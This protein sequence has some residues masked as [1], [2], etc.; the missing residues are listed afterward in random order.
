MG[1]VAAGAAAAMILVGG[2]GGT[3]NAAETN[4]AYVDGHTLTATNPSGTSTNPFDHR[5]TGENDSDAYDPSNRDDEGMLAGMMLTATA[6]SGA[7]VILGRR[8]N[9]E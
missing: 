5:L 6:L 2:M 3:A 8:R 1:R 9:R 4:P 7:T